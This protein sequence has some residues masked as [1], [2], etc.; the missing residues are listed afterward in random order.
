M[1]RVPS[2]ASTMQT[3]TCSFFELYQSPK[4]PV[5]PLPT[6]TQPTI[7]HD[8]LRPG[9]AP[10]Y[11]GRDCLALYAN[12]FTAGFVSNL[13]ASLPTPVLKTYLHLSPTQASVLQTI[14]FIAWTLKALLGGVSDCFPI[15]GS[16]RKA[17]MLLGWVV[18]AA[19]FVVLAVLDDAP[20]LVV[21]ALVGLTQVGF[22]VSLTAGDALMVDLAQREPHATRGRLQ[23]F[24]FAS[25][26]LGLAAA[27]LG[28]SMALHSAQYG[29]PFSFGLTLRI[30]FALCAIPCITMVPVVVCGVHEVAR[31]RVVNVPE[32]LAAFWGLAQK[33]VFWQSLLF[34]FCFELL[35]FGFVPLIDAVVAQR[36][37]HAD[38]AAVNS[39]A[40]VGGLL[41]QALAMALVGVAGTQCNWRHMIAL[42]TVVWVAHET[43]V[44]MLVIFS[45][46][47]TPAFFLVGTQSA[48]FAQGIQQL[49]ISF[50]YVEI[51]DVGMEGISYG[52]LSTMANLGQTLG[53]AL[54]GAVNSAFGVSDKDVQADAA[55]TRVSVASIY[56]VAFGS[57]LLACAFLPWLPL[58]KDHT[59]FLRAYGGP[60]NPVAAAWTL[61]LCA[62]SI[63]LGFVINILADF[64]STAC[65]VLAG[66]PGC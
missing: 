57:A 38:N 46:V 12:Y 36:W 40:Q 8:S 65:M 51:I 59:A 60:K 43:L 23:A 55:R 20:G 48:F 31:R 54:S 5:L 56:A 42:S 11:L 16:R 50:V 53:P 28:T 27:Q 1:S 24:T 21:A 49:A 25:R 37:G 7:L 45:V 18:C 19:S 66:G 3:M 33:R 41:L 9:A 17:Y 52:M 13:A 26:Y 2:S 14:T 35:T 10:R 6:T 4:C 32:H 61:S 64:D 58:Q 22:M 34:Q 63:V 47:R 15:A 29:G 62:A 39:F 30:F 44:Y